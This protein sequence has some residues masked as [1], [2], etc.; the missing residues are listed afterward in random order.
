MIK[1]SP[2]WNHPLS[3]GQVSKR[4]C[5]IPS[6]SMYDYYCPEDHTIMFEFHHPMEGTRPGPLIWRSICI[7][8]AREMAAHL[9]ETGTPFIMGTHWYNS[10]GRQVKKMPIVRAWKIAH[11]VI[12]D[13]QP[14][15]DY[16]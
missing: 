13:V 11:G 4:V 16:V 7:H 14:A 2:Y 8:R 3:Y 5:W 10:E 9:Y 15:S 6:L 1:V 12:T